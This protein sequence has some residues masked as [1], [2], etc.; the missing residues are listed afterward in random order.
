[1]QAAASGLGA[2]AALLVCTQEHPGLCSRITAPRLHVQACLIPI[3]AAFQNRPLNLQQ[4]QQQ[5]TTCR[6]WHFNTD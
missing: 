5:H 2:F 4:H 6:F 3:L 1:M